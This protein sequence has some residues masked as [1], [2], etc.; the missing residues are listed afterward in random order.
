MDKILLWKENAPDMDVC[1]AQLAPSMQPFEVA[2]SRG[3]VLV[4]PGGAYMGKAPHEGKPICEML[5]SYGISAFCLD[6]RVAPC[7]HDTP[8][9]DAQRALRI[10]RSMGYEKVGILGFSAGGNLCCSAATLYDEGD[11]QNEDPIERY[12]SRPDVFVP[13]YA[14]VSMVSYGHLGSTMNLLGDH[15]ENMDLR[16]RYSAELNVTANTPPAF[17]WH[18]ADDDLV[19]IQN[20]L[21]LAS[22]LAEK[23]VEFEM[24]VYPHGRHGLGL[25]TDDPVVSSWGKDCS[26]FLCD[27]GFGR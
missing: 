4:C 11:S 25:A 6:Y 18:T 8:L 7:R 12:T 3:A 2:G 1:G 21:M 27:H 13:C 23:K 24:H 22:A 20:A 15:Y 16:K 14:V 19:E 9:C 10:I 26:R 17:I 5:N